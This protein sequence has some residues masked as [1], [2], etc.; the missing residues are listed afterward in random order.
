[1]LSLDQKYGKM[2]TKKTSWWRHQM[3]TFSALLALC[4]GNSP[5]TGEFPSQR[6]VTRSF[7]FFFDLHLNE[8]LSKQSWG[9]WFETP[10]R[11]LWHHCNDKC[12]WYLF[13]PLCKSN[14]TFLN[15]KIFKLWRFQISWKFGPFKKKS[16]LAFM[17]NFIEIDHS[18]EHPSL[19]PETSWFFD[20]KLEPT[21]FVTRQNIQ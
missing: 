16:W 5:V 11:S 8:R 10:L 4:A 1:M 9:W 18:G 15:V 6:P 17:L 21:M 19:N 14:G 20:F 2:K 3:E 7:D 12:W 13:T